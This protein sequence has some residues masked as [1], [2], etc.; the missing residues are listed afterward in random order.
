[1]SF[2]LDGISKTYRSG[3]RSVPA[4]QPTTF[5]VEPGDFVSLIGPSGCGKSTLLYIAAGLEAPS[6]G[7]ITLDG[8]ELRHPGRERG[9]VFQHYTLFPWLTVRENVRF[10]HELRANQDFGRPMSAILQELAYADHLLEIMGLE[11][12]AQSYP[13]ELSGGMKQRVAIARALA[14]R[15]RILLMDEPFGALDAQTREEMQ[16]LMMLLRLHEKTTVV[17]VT[18]DIDEALYLSS[19][20]LVFSAHPGRLIEE[21]AIPFPDDRTLD[22]KLEPEF[23]RLKRHLLG[24]LHGGSREGF[25]R[26]AILA[27][28]K[29]E[30]HTTTTNNT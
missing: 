14:N 28:L 13:R 8:R 21:T 27:R 29:G 20:V 10:S 19:R 18:H 15:P 23:L 11:R 6:T 25:D 1:M 24:L 22:I 17:F 7:S 5:T 12:F 16:E 4:L 26:R 2:H 3:R 30:P 9:M